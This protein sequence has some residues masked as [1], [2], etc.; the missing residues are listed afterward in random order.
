V[1]VDLRA[2]S[3]TFGQWVGI[4]LSDA[5]PSQVYLPPG[6]AHGF[7]VI[8]ESAEILYKCTDYYYPG[9]EGGL[10][11]SD[12]DVGV[13]WPNSEPILATSDK[14]FPRLRDIATSRLPRV[15]FA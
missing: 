5:R 2:E 3:P 14:E 1:G 12:P 7:C 8:S 15:S 13:R 6:V 4:E 9:D 10:L 11:W